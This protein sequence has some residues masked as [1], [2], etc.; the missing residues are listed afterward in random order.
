MRYSSA[1]KASVNNSPEGFWCLNSKPNC[2]K[3]DKK[4]FPPGQSVSLLRWRASSSPTQPWFPRGLH[5]RRSR[6]KSSPKRRSSR[7]TEDR[8]CCARR[9]PLGSA[10]PVCSHRAGT[11]LFTPPPPPPPRTHIQPPSLITTASQLLLPRE[12]LAPPAWTLVLRSSM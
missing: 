9:S 5:L 12:S 11:L 8:C 3:A 4:T 7:E 1:A 6:P 2:F 10:A